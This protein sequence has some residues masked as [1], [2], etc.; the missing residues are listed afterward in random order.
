MNAASAGA[1]AHTLAE[2]RER[3]LLFR[4]LATLRTDIALFQDVDEL[5]WQGPGADF[6]ALGARLDSAVTQAKG[7]G[8]GVK[9]TQANPQP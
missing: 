4:T 7:K 2:Q 5:R 3:A 6:E 1:L 9:G 8:R